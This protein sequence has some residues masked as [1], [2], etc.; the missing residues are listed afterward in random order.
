MASSIQEARTPQRLI[1]GTGVGSSFRL[2]RL[3]AYS[4][5]AGGLKSAWLDLKKVS[6]ELPVT[7]AN[8][9]KGLHKAILEKID[10]RCK[11]AS[12][13]IMGSPDI[14]EKVLPELSRHPII[15]GAARTLVKVFNSSKSNR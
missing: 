2:A 8:S 6:F 3:Q 7:V 11:E 13:V 10:R 12:I 9:K 5:Q 1:Q 15:R 4:Q 14:E